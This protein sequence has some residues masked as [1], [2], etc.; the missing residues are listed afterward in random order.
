[1]I[2]QRRKFNPQNVERF[3]AL[4]AGGNSEAVAC[5]QIGIRM[6][7]LVDWLENKPKFAQRYAKA[8]SDIQV[9][10]TERLLKFTGRDPR[11]A[12]FFHVKVHDDFRKSSGDDGATSLGEAKPLKQRDPAEYGKRMDDIFGVKPSLDANG[13][14]D[15]SEQPAPLN[16]ELTESE[17]EADGMTVAQTVAADEAAKAYGERV[18]AEY[19]RSLPAVPGKGTSA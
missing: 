15:E 13:E 2:K 7:T 5:A 11:A 6:E 9:L 18:A 4:V 17:D 10:A 8:K 19:E 1:M 12:Q 3:C 14:E 16:G